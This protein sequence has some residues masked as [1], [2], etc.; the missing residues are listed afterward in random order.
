[1]EKLYEVDGQQVTKEQLEEMQ[2]DCSIRLKETEPGSGKFKKL[3]K[4]EE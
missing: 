4:L 3:I 1:M 2:K